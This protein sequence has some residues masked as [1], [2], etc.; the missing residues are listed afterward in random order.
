[1]HIKACRLGG[2]QYEANHITFQC[3]MHGVKATP[4]SLAML[5]T[6]SLPTKPQYQT[7]DELSSKDASRSTFTDDSITNSCENRDD[8]MN[9]IF[10][11]TG[12]Q[13]SVASAET[14][15][16]E[17]MRDKQLDS[18]S[19]PVD[20]Y[21]FPEAE[22]D[23]Q[24]NEWPDPPAAPANEDTAEEVK[25]TVST[26]E[27]QTGFWLPPPPPPP[28]T[29]VPSPPKRARPKLLEQQRSAKSVNETEATELSSFETGGHTDGGT[30]FIGTP[31]TTLNKGDASFVDS[32]GN[33]TIDA[34]GFPLVPVADQSYPNTPAKSVKSV[35]A[36]P[37]CA[38]DSPAKAMRSVKS[39]PS[40]NRL[41]AHAKLQA[42][43]KEPPLDV[44]APPE[45]ISTDDD[46][47]LQAEPAVMEHKEPTLDG[48]GPPESISTGDDDDDSGVQAGPT[49][50]E[51]RSK[52][53]NETMSPAERKLG[54]AKE[55]LSKARSI[56]TDDDVDMILQE[57][58]D[59]DNSCDKDDA[60]GI[61]SIDDTHPVMNSGSD[62]FIP[63]V[64][65]VETPQSALMEGS[66]EALESS[67]EILDS[68]CEIPMRAAK[69][70]QPTR[71]KPASSKFRCSDDV[72]YCNI[73]LVEVEKTMW[74]LIDAFDERAGKCGYAVGCIDRVPKVVNTSV[75]DT[76]SLLEDES[77]LN[78]MAAENYSV[79]LLD[80][81]TIDD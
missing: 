35:K 77:L 25:D 1:M 8:S 50:K 42:H 51:F 78:R 75:N 62:T 48:E 68:S 12:K 28:K 66:F 33:V 60:F 41:L 24:V 76:F 11:A 22:A 74:E 67:I 29:P 36:M 44:E 5:P 37:T 32:V 73:N 23:F 34:F 14:E 71:R 20:C 64:H 63:K 3:G 47:V 4:R 2:S 56:V 54:V 70:I 55:L 26:V 27:F 9:D 59:P 38:R 65:R 80:S 18:S 19:S 31:N 15:A 81:L 7:V 39:A 72:V 21:G 58:N 6:F 43:Y 79:S 49:V 16:R 46:S 52:S 69:K 40:L 30:F 45:Y 13:F 61:T 17:A 57:I 10:S 53:F